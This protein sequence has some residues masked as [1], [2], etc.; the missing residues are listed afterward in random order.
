MRLLI[1]EDD[2]LLGDGIRGGLTQNGYAVD[3]V[4]DG[5]AA[6]TALLTNDYELMV[7]DLGLPKI[8]GL[9]LLKKIRK[10]GNDLP[11][12]ILT[13]QD[14]VEDR[15]KGLDSG[16]DDYLT[17]PFDLDEVYA[18]IRALIRRGSGRANPVINHHNIQLDPAAHTVTKDGKVVDLSRR[19]YDVLLE[20]FENS[21]RVLSRMRL[22]EGLY[23]IDDDMASNAVEV[24]IHHLRKKLGSELIR[25]I[26]GV[27]YTVDKCNS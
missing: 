27:G 6:E 17:K 2:S 11:V 25:T 14:G 7:L 20:L 12:I 26:R 22:E 24:H 4:E 1:V 19:E 16:A 18:R 9:E 15:V 10:S 23:S 3:W 8:S 13:A 5:E 21:G